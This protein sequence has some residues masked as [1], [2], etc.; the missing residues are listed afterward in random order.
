M[1]AQVLSNVGRTLFTGLSM[2]TGEMLAKMLIFSAIGAGTR[3][4]IDKIFG[5]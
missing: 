1:L 4:L 2:I 5:V 3:W